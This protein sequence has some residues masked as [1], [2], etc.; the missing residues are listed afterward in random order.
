MRLHYESRNRFLSVLYP[1]DNNTPNVN[2]AMCFFNLFTYLTLGHEPWHSIHCGLPSA[3]RP[4]SSWN[5]LLWC[6]LEVESFRFEPVAKEVRRASV[7]LVP[8]RLL[9]YTINWWTQIIFRLL[10]TVG[11]SGTENHTVKY[12]GKDSGTRIESVICIYMYTMQAKITQLTLYRFPGQLSL[13]I[14]IYM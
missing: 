9:I 4:S 6:W 5:A 11:T 1:S 7:H 2:K 3:T 8:P 14:Y 13:G 12:T 10:S